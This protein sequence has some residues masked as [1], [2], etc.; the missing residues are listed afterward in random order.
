MK[1]TKIIVSLLAVVLCV[2]IVLGCV[3]CEPKDDNSIKIKV[4]VSEI[5]GVTDLTQ[6]QIDAF[7][8]ANPDIKIE[9]TLEGIPEGDAATKIIEDVDTAPDLF[10]FAQD[11]LARLVQTGAL[12]KIVGNAKTQIADMNDANSVKAGQ[13]AGEQYAFPLTADNGYFLYY[14]KSVLSDDDVKTLEGI[15]AK[16]ETENKFFNFELE[17]SAWYTASFFMA[18]GCHS[19]WTTRPDG[20]FVSFD[21]DW[22][23]DKGITAL[24]GMQKLLKSKCYQSN[25]SSFDGTAAIV[26][27]AW[28]SGAAATAYGENL[29]AT[30]LPTFTVGE[31][32]YQLGSFTGY[33]LMGIKPQGD[34]KKAAALQKLALWLSGEA[35]QQQRFE[36]FGWGPSNK[37]V[38]ASDAVKANATLNA[39]AAQAQYGIPQ[40]QIWGGWWDIAKVVATGA[41]EAT[42]DAGLQTVLTTYYNAIN[43]VMSLTPEQRKAYT[44]I[45]SING[46]SWGTDFE[47]V[48]G[49]DGTW[50]SKDAFAMTETDEFKVR[51]GFSWDVA[52]GN[53]DDNANTG[54]PT[55]NKGNYKV[56]T[57]GTYNFQLVVTKGENDKLTA[58]ITLVPAE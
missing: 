46:S 33:K 48:E 29:G 16:C 12:T 42:D 13:V 2:A 24:K 11:Q 34:A 10:C 57:A 8:A 47:M 1:K 36:Q 7:N 38:A 39:F 3:A 56:E 20:E 44:V 37:V 49:P 6:Q 31:E 52:W 4:W 50:T 55:S 14:D 43:A 22:N 18:T 26:T 40:G 17:G 5:N 53:N 15:I 41:K 28:N 25:S 9:A 35:C 54:I 19:N 58:V 23:S 51:Q 32:T 30:K 45:G 27:G 21:D